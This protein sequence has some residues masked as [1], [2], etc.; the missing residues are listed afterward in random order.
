MNRSNKFLLLSAVVLF[1]CFSVYAQNTGSVRGGSQAQGGIKIPPVGAVNNNYSTVSG[2]SSSTVSGGTRAFETRTNQVGASN[3][4]RL[5]GE[6]TG[7]YLLVPAIIRKDPAGTALRMNTSGASIIS[8]LDRGFF[9]GLTDVKTQL[10]ETGIILEIAESRF[11]KAVEFQPDNYIYHANLAS[12][13][14]RQKKNK[15]ALAAIRRAMELDP[16]NEVLKNYEQVI[17][18][19]NVTVIVLDDNE[20]ENE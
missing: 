17:L 18:G 4:N 7:E 5:S 15:E 13:L 8:L 11:R 2:T 3:Y 14:F 19:V 9:G 1:S 16:D 20:E 6:G 10:L 12:V